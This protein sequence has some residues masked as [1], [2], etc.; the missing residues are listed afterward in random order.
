MNS[1][2]LLKLGV[3]HECLG[4]AIRAIQRSPVR[5]ALKV[6]RSRNG[7]RRSWP[8]RKRSW[9][10]R[11]WGRLLKPL[12]VNASTS[13]QSRFRTRPGERTRL[14]G[15]AHPD[16]ASLQPARRRRSGVDA[17]RPCRLRP[18]DRRRAGLRECRDPVCRRRR[19]C[20]PHETVGPRHAADT[21]ARQNSTPIASRWKTERDSVS[22]PN[23]RQP[24]RHAVMDRRLVRHARS[25]ANARTEPGSS[26]ERPVRETTLPSSACLM[27]ETPDRRTGPG[28]RA[29]RGP[30]EP[31]RQPWRRCG[32][33]LDLQR[34][35]PIATASTLL[36]IWLSIWP[37]SIWTARRARSTG[38]R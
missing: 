36:P 4:V 2:Q 17:R 20:L 10:T 34:D 5:R 30:A 15:I 8:N 18:A 11:I 28:G 1:R 32:R 37:G 3:P 9:S 22:G 12:F 7:S 19:Y 21:I 24:N 26:W 35:R 33:L 16:A 23:T 38:R 27:L 6:K 14:I 29:V 25:P 31:Q 13:R